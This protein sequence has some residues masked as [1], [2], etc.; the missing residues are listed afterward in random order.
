MKPNYLGI[1]NDCNPRLVSTQA[2]LLM[3]ERR[4]KQQNRQHPCCIEQHP[5]L[6]LIRRFRQ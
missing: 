4:H 5:P 2:R 6:E 3:S 1:Q